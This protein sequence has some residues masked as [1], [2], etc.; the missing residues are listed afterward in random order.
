MHVGPTILVLPN[1]WDVASARIFEKAGFPAL[2]TTSAGIANSLGYPDGQRVPLD[3]MLHV[4]E[5]IAEAVHVPVTADMEAGYGITDHAIAKTVA[6]VISAGAIGI[7]LEDGTTD[8][9]TALCDPDVHIRKIGIARQVAQSTGIPLVINA[10]TD[11][12]LLQVGD[13]QSRMRETILRGNA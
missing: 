13:P 9:E 1:T 3:E 6:G 10:Q 11:S 4:V 2:A 7:N 8:P 12:F 5:R